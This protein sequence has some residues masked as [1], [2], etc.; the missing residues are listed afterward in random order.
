MKKIKEFWLK[1]VRWFK[2]WFFYR[3]IIRKILRSKGVDEKRMLNHFT[4]V[5]YKSILLNKRMMN[6]E[7][8][9]F[10]KMIELAN[11][12]FQSHEYLDIKNKFEDESFNLDI[13]ESEDKK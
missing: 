7:E 13:N 12:N 8:N 3:P 4:Y 1:I 6:I 2:Y 10:I 9:N 11:N 5:I